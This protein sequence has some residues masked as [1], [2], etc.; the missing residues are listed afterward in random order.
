LA[1]SANTFSGDVVVAAAGGARP[2]LRR[3][4]ARLPELHTLSGCLLGLELGDRDQHAWTLDDG[5][6]LLLATDGLFDQPASEQESL[7]KRLANRSGQH[8]SSTVRNEPARSTLPIFD[9][10]PNVHRPATLPM[11]VPTSKP[12]PP[13]CKK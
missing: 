1:Q 3:S 5:D 6:E 13:M 2:N 4:S 10:L 11:G 12:Q 8:V 7:G 9:Q